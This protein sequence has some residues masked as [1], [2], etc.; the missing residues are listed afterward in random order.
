MTAFFLVRSDGVDV[1][2]L[3]F[4]LCSVAVMAALGR[5]EFGH[6]RT[7]FV[8]RGV[9]TLGNNLPKCRSVHCNAGVVSRKPRLFR[10]LVPGPWSVKVRAGF[11]FRLSLFGQI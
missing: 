4:G 7:Y 10:V 1:R 6:V 8:V 3:L 9:E 5:D 2:L 11:A